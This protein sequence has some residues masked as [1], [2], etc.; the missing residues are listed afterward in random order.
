[1]TNET[2]HSNHAHSRNGVAIHA[3]EK[4]AE[5][6]RREIAEVLGSLQ[7]SERG[8]AT[9]VAAQRLAEIGPNAVAQEKAHGAWRRLLRTARNP[10]V[11][12]LAILATISFSTGDPRGGGG[13]SL[14]GILGVSFLVSVEA[15]AGASAAQLT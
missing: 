12:L 9:A 8:L 7:S 5:A 2:L 10:L 11:I 6:G 14:M 3:S 15:R 1:M 4:L 13:M